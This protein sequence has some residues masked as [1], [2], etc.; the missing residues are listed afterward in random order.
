[1]RKS[2]A[3]ARDMYEQVMTFNNYVRQLSL[4]RSEG[5]LLRHLSQGYKTCAQNVPESFRTEPFDDIIAY[6]H[7]TITRLDSTDRGLGAHAWMEKSKTRSPGHGPPPPMGL[8][9]K[10]WCR[11]EEREV[12]A[13]W[14]EEARAPQAPQ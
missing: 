11:V 2:K 6:L 8:G 10:R 3:I 13:A 4:S 12:K 14:T 7:T 1:M 9:Q 5:V